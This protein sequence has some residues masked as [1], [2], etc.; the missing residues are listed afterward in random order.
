MISFFVRHPIAA[1][2]SVLFHTVLIL[3]IVAYSLSHETKKPIMKISLDGTKTDKLTK[4]IKQTKPLKTFA[5]NGNLIAEQLAILKEQEANKLKTQKQL[6][7]QTKVEQK[8]LDELQRKK[9]IA[10]KR[11]LAERKKIDAAKKTAAKEKLKAEKA[12]KLAK[13]E[14]AKVAKQKKQTAIAKAAA[15]KAEKAS[16]IAENKKKEAQKKLAETKKQQALETEKAAEL[17][18]QIAIKEQEKKKIE[19]Q[20][21]KLA[22]DS[23]EAQM[24]KEIEESEAANERI[25]VAQAAKKNKLA[26]QKE[27]ISL[28]QTYISSIAAK[29]KSKWRTVVKI[30]PRA[31]C[32]VAIRQNSKY[33]VLSVKVLECNKFATTQFKK[34]AEKAVRR[35]SPLPS[36]PVKELFE[37]DIKFIFKP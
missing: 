13:V 34:D 36:P 31:Q 18:K 9:W 3:G 11:L 24:N 7:T 20:N 17:S 10:K 29:V 21:K 15:A 4:E 19:A 25:K 14:I 27:L 2:F 16:Q 26:R 6:A 30:D 35:A 37:A 1:M 32:S 5:V 22:E 23:L 8:R 33:E 28:G 12:R